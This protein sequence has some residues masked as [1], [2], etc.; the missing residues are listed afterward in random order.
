MNTFNIN[1][2]WGKEIRWNVSI[3]TCNVY[4]ENDFVRYNIGTTQGLYI[5]IHVYNS[6]HYVI[7][8]LWISILFERKKLDE[9]NS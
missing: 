7:W 2:N 1:S 8:I 4:G 3:L 5:M 6:K 9:V